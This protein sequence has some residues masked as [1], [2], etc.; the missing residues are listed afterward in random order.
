MI[1]HHPARI[2]TVIIHTGDINEVIKAKLLLREAANFGNLFRVGN[3]QG[4]FAAKL[5]RFGDEVTE[6]GLDFIGGF[7]G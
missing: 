7:E 3:F 5:R 1:D 6:L 2:F 4:N